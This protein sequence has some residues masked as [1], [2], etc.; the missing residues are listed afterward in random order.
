MGHLL[1]LFV[2]NPFRDVNF[3]TKVDS[4]LDLALSASA[5]G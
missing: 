2:R 4:I 1:D 3:Y 5:A